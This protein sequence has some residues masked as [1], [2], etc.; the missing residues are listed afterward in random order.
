[1]NRYVFFKWREVSSRRYQI[2]DYFALFAVGRL[3]TEICEINRFEICA[4]DT[5]MYQGLNSMILVKH[6]N[7]TKKHF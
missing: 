4:N 6:K 5:M 1:M 7:W 2:N 3:K